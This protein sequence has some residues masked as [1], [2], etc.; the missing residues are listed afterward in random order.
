[1]VGTN[2][3]QSHKSGPG[4]NLGWIRTCRSYADA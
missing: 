2:G 4:A 1:M 3:I